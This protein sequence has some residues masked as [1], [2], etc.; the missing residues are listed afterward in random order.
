MQPNNKDHHFDA[1]QLQSVLDN[2]KPGLYS[3]LKQR[4]L[5]FAAHLEAA[6]QSGNLT[7]AASYWIA[8]MQSLQN[9]IQ[10][11]SLPSYQQTGIWPTL[12]A[13]HL[14]VSLP[15]SGCTSITDTDLA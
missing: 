5:E 12:H 1:N 6:E 10:N 7:R 15:F 11:K 2:I 4:Y 13:V 8:W 3:E 9:A 14:L